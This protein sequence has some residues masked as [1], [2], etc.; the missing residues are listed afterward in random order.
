MDDN[1]SKLEVN[2]DD[3]GVVNLSFKTSFKCPRCGLLKC[4]CNSFCNIEGEGKYK[5]SIK[6]NTMSLKIDR[7]E[8]G[9]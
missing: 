8:G 7:I 5:I 6:N 2:Y 4:N 9:N 1:K 3:Y